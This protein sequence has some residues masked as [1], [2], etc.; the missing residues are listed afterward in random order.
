MF[1]ASHRPKGM[2]FPACQECNDSSRKAELVAG[3]MS[4]IFPD[5][6]PGMLEDEQVRL[7]RSV[8]TNIPGL[9]QEMV[10]SAIQLSKFH[11]QKHRLPF[12][13]AGALNAGGPIL[14]KLM[15]AFGAKLGIALH[16]QSLGHALPLNGAVFV[17]W[18]SNY[19]AVT[20]ELPDD[21]I[22]LMGPSASLSQGR[23][24]V[25]DQF[26][27][28]RATTDEGTMAAHFASFRQSFG[29]VMF[30]ADDS[31]KMQD[32]PPDHVFRPGVFV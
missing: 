19:D 17:R 14:N 27:F 24:T 23:W 20:D 29:I 31:S 25:E 2:E 9:I 22:R 7:M 30:S 12:N 28:G 1:N 11:S 13:A 5:P 18:Y 32:A 4:R 21:L 3:M 6:P 10:P 15:M 16:Y 8:N 26:Q